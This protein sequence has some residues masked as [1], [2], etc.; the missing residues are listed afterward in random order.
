MFKSY[1]VECVY[2]LNGIFTSP[3]SLLNFYLL[4]SQA[5]HHCNQY[6]DSFMATLASPEPNNQS[7]NFCVWCM[8]VCVGVWMGLVAFICNGMCHI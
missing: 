6:Y 7:V 3:V 5:A 8:C 1:I 2:V 4:H